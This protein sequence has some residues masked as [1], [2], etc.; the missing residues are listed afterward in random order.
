[1][2]YGANR[3]V[4]RHIVPI[5]MEVRA[6]GST[7][8]DGPISDQWS[9]YSCIVVAGLSHKAR[10]SRS[11]PSR[12]SCLHVGSVLW[13]IVWKEQQRNH[14]V[15]QLGE[16]LHFGDWFSEP[17]VLVV[18]G[19]HGARQHQIR[20]RCQRVSW[21]LDGPRGCGKECSCLESGRTGTSPKNEAL[22]RDNQ[23]GPL[24]RVAEPTQ[25]GRDK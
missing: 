15:I 2:I 7:S 22:T 14:K 21:N 10:Q 20:V 1:L 25:R 9:L 16:N 6:T 23:H 3:I 11:L 17:D 4:A 13:R 8:I 19:R 5:S 24:L 12:L 18:I